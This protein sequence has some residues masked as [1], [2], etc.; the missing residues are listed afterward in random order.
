MDLEFKQ[1]EHTKL[2]RILVDLP[3]TM[4]SEWQIDVKKSHAI[5]PAALREDLRRIAK[6]ARSRA[7]EVYRHRA[8][9]LRGPNSER[10]EHVWF[11]MVKDN[12]IFFKINRKHPVIRRIVEELKDTRKNL[13]V[14]LDLLESS[15]PVE[16]IWLES[17]EKPDQF[18]SQSESETYDELQ[19]FGLRLFKVFVAE[20]MSPKDAYTRLL[21][22][23]PFSRFPRL[24]ATI[25]SELGGS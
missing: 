20:G 5:P 2:A 1:E 23:E 3:N 9:R 13:K 11:K 14:L 4:D 21:D 6:A 19:D 25:E 16:S 10:Y 24:I 17:A 22:I 15:L 18:G 7:Q 8:A 12:V